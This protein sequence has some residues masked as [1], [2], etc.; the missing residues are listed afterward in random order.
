MF[1][2]YFGGSYPGISF[3]DGTAL[4]S[5]VHDSAMPYDA[6]ARLLMLYTQYEHFRDSYHRITQHAES[7]LKE[8]LYLI[9]NRARVQMQILRKRIESIGF[10]GLMKESRKKVVLEGVESIDIYPHIASVDSIRLIDSNLLWGIG[11]LDILELQDSNIF[12]QERILEVLRVLAD[13]TKFELLRILSEDTLYGTEL[14]ERLLLSAAT[15]SHHVAQLGALRLVHIIKQ[16][17]RIYYRTN[18]ELLSQYMDAAKGMLIGEMPVAERSKGKA[19]EKRMDT[20][21]QPQARQAEQTLVEKLISHEKPDSPIESEFTFH[22]PLDARAKWVRLAEMMPWRR[23]EV[24]YNRHLESAEE[25]TVKTSR[26]AFGALYIQM[27]DGLTDEQ[28]RNRIQESPEM[29]FFCGF[30]RY[31]AETPFET[32]TMAQFRRRITPESIGI[33]TAELFV[34]DA[35]DQ[36]ERDGLIMWE[37]STADDNAQG[38]ATRSALK[39]SAHGNGEKNRGILVLDAACAVVRIEDSMSI[40]LL[41]DAR[42]VAEK[43]VETLYARVRTSYDEKPRTYRRKAHKDY[44]AYSK[45]NKKST[46]EMRVA[47][48][49]QLDY[50][51]HDIRTIEDLLSRGASLTSLGG[52]TYRRL[53][54]AIE[55]YRQWKQMN[56][57]KTQRID[58]Q[59]MSIAHPYLR[60]I[61]QSLE[62]APSEKGSKVAMALTGGASFITNIAWENFPEAGLLSNAV[63]EYRD[64]FGCYPQAIIADHTY[65]NREG[66]RYCMERGI[67]LSG[68]RLGRKTVLTQQRSIGEEQ[69][70]ISRESDVGPKRIMR[71]V[72]DPSH[73]S[74]AM[75][76]LVANMER[77]LRVQDFPSQDWRI[78]YDFREMCLVVAPYIVPDSL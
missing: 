53:L 70:M 42:S 52:Q 38:A 35:L 65:P 36:M 24:E 6:Q 67:L 64:M 10:E 74:V 58:G 66:M 40:E 25:N 9:E 48:R 49:K 43:V 26:L 33:L 8:K 18:T 44:L 16:A 17:N 1:E 75:G 4:Q 68:P 51:A 39:K 55:V 60:P 12:S 73:T 21:D 59:I 27:T 30:E 50:I 56:D 11:V 47:V 14:A 45:K 57:T 62:Q 2:R 46:K 76:F 13:R 29:Q 61:V 3:E 5:F 19:S 71:N 7:L 34:D 37:D 22:G 77:K 20:K 54:I 15:I 72:D 32:A 41:A 23:I 78:D 31:R 28:T 69:T 63:E